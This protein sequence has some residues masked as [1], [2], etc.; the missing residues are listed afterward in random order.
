[1][2][3]RV[4]SSQWHAQYSSSELS[5]LVGV[6]MDAASELLIQFDGAIGPFVRLEDLK[7]TG[8]LDAGDY[9]IIESEMVRWGKQERIIAC[10]IRR[11]I[12]RL[13]QETPGVSMVAQVLPHPVTVATCRVAATAPDVAT[14]G[15]GEPAPLIICAAP[16]GHEV[17]RQDHP[18]VPI[19]PEEIAAEVARCAVEGATVVHLH[20]RNEQGSPT[21]D[22]DVFAKAVR[23][24]R[25]RCDVIIQ[26]S[27]E[28]DSNM[29]VETRCAGL[30]VP[31]VD[32][33]SVATGTVNQHDHIYFNSRP[34]MERVGQV[35]QEHNLAAAVE[36]MDLGFIEN[37]KTM[38]RKGLLK[39]PTHFTLIMG[40]RGGMGARSSFLDVAVDQIP[41]GSTWS[42]AG[43]GRHQLPMAEQALAL[44][45]H[46]RVGFE[47][48]LIVSGGT[49]AQGNAALVAAVADM[50]RQR[51]RK[52]AT[53]SEAR[54]ILGLEQKR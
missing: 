21:H 2:K 34:I 31:G 23:Q 42:V 44:G 39:L 20:V 48:G 27:T 8:G 26:V 4:P 16:T 7:L 29:D 5:W 36:V 38:A 47:N 13:P 43:I 10:T 37:A 50:A 15:Q 14:K 6:V 28:G 51:N 25:Q 40:T 19:T 22:P 18:N 53:I 41:R 35:I 1:M 33:G 32:M 12:A 30:R 52:I 11:T 54:S 46:V 45:G 17:T 9:I 49:K 24:I 3:V